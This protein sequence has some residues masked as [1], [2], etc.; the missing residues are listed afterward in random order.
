MVKIE[1]LEAFVNLVGKK[2]VLATGNLEEDDGSEEQEESSSV[3][4]IENEH[5]KNLPLG[6]KSDV[7]RRM[8]S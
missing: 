2:D 7:Y 1:G 6:M 5:F 3:E 8:K 4:D